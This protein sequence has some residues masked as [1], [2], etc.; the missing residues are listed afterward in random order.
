MLCCDDEETRK[1]SAFPT[2]QTVC[3][4]EEKSLEVLLKQMQMCF[5][6][7]Q[8]RREQHEGGLGLLGKRVSKQKVLLIVF[9]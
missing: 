7:S 8:A 2:V 4:R 5:F 9:S 6:A 3:R 1:S